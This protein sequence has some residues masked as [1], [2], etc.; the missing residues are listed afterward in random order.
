[1]SKQKFQIGDNVYV[2][3]GRKDEIGRDGKVANIIYKSFN[4]LCY[5]VVY[6]DDNYPR[7]GIFYADMFKITTF[8]RR[9]RVSRPAF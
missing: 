6:N 7:S 3:R 4:R 8:H 9:G 1:M 5:I 2:K